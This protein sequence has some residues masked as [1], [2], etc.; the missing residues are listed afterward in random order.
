MTFF[1][2]YFSL[3]HLHIEAQLFCYYQ[4]YISS[5]VQRKHGGT[6]KTVTSNNNERTND[7]WPIGVKALLDRGLLLAQR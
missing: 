7:E 6:K 4:N 1:G 5:A 2:I 3:A